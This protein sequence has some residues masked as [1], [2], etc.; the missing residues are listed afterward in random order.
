MKRSLKSLLAALVLSLSLAAP[1]LAGSNSIA[2]SDQQFYHR[3]RSTPSYPSTR[4]TGSFRQ[5]ESYSQKGNRGK[6]FFK[7][8][9]KS[10]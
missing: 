5:P 2:L 10:N 1:V 9:L 7:P 4:Q 8:D 6:D 3:E